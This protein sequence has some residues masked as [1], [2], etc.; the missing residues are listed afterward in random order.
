M[1]SGISY[2]FYYLVDYSF[3]EKL[4]N[5]SVNLFSDRNM[6]STTVMSALRR[7]AVTGL[8]LLTSISKH[9]LSVDITKH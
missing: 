9:S 6:N 4:F 7:T 5:Y 2:I 1:L 3:L 8:D